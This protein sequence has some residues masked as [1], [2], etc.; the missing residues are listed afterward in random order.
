MPDERY[1]SVGRILK[2]HGVRGEVKV[3][4]LTD[5]PARFKRLGRVFCLLNSGDRLTLHVEQ[6]RAAGPDTIL[7]KFEEYGSP[8]AV[9]ALREALIQVPR[10]ESPPLPEGKVY[11]ADMI[12]LTARRQDT[13]EALGTVTAIVSAGNDL[14]EI[15]TPEGVERLIPWVDAFVARIDLA[16]REVWL[17]PAP[18]LLEL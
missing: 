6:A 18:G 2:P 7:L 8:E 17:T 15:T 3:A 12:G 4:P 16:A 1:V 5:D 9:D 13:G 10:S 14:L 11:F